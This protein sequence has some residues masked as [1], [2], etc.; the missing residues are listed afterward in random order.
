[1]QQLDRRAYVEARMRRLQRLYAER[2]TVPGGE[3]L[4]LNL[5]QRLYRAIVSEG[6]GE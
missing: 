2:A 4:T 6:Y 5:L 3:R 1:M